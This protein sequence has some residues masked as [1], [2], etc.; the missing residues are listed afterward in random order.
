MI[1]LIEKIEGEAKLHF[2]N[3]SG[4]IG[5]VGIE[6]MHSRGIET[7]LEGKAA[8][9]ALVIN[10]RICGICGHAHLIATAKALEAC[11]G[12][13]EPSPKAQ[14]LRQ[15]TLDF[16]LILNHIKWFYLVLYPLFGLKQDIAK[17]NKLSFTLSKAI[18]IFGG[19]YPHNSYAVPGGITP[20]VLRSDI[21][22]AKQLLQEVGTFFQD[23]LI[24]TKKQF[25]QC[26][27][28][29]TLLGAGGDLPAFAR[30]LQKKGLC[31]IGKSYDRFFVLGQHDYFRRGKSHKTKRLQNLEYKF[32]REH[33]I[34]GS[35]AKNVT[36]KGRY[37]EVGPLARAMVGKIALIKDAHRRYGDSL[38]TRIIARVCE[39]A[40]LLHRCEQRLDEI[41]VTQPSFIAPP[42]PIERLS[43]EGTAA[44]EAARGSLLHRVVLREGIIQKYEIITPTQWNLG[45]GDKKHPG[46]AQKAMQGARDAQQAKQIFKSFDVCSVCTT[47]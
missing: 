3:K 21:I 31:D 35:Q 33:D 6:F 26:D 45:N 25:W 15:M 18:A 19:Q 12:G 1:E 2:N 39:S 43:G 5:H 4:R 22:K 44:V 7:M 36:Y 29:D 20:Q 14:K 37:Y 11:Y 17:V 42:T 47:H 24:R 38:F 13:F 23:H 27:S 28:I 46:T 9:D 34:T 32:I 30:M 41:D 16:E 40:Q 8:T 10:P